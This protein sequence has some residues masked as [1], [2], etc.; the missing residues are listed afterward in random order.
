M[1]SA[2][3]S[4]ADVRAGHPS[5]HHTELMAPD[6]IFVQERI[7]FLASPADRRATTGR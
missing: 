2:H 7:P 3:S 6:D 4:G 5:V 1:K